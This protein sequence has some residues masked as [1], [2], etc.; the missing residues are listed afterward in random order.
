MM[1]FFTGLALVFLMFFCPSP[2]LRAGTF[3]VE[4]RAELNRLMVELRAQQFLTHATF[5]PKDT[6]VQ[7]LADRMMQ[8]GVRRAASEWIDTQFQLPASTHQQLAEDMVAADGFETTQASINVARY[9]YHAWWHNA[10]T[11]EDQLRQRVAWALMQICVVGESGSNFNNRAAGKLGKGR[12][13][14]LSNYYDMLLNNSFNNYRD[15]LGD[16]TF[17]PIMGV[18]LSH[19]RNQKQDASQNIFP[20]ENYAREILQLFSIGLYRL[21]TDGTFQRNPS[22]DLIPTYDN[23][24][25]ETF[26]RLFTG[27]TYNQSNSLRSGTVN[28]QEPMMMFDEF[29]DQD[30]KQV[31]LGQTLPGGVGGVADINAGLDNIM[32]HP[33]AG[34]FIVRRLIQRLVRSNPSKGYMRRVVRK[35]N[36]NGQGVKG[37]MKAV[38]KAILLDQEAWDGIRMVRRANPWRL[39]VTGRGT[40]RSRLSEPVVLYASFI[41]RYG[42]TDNPNGYFLM[43]KLNFNWA[44]APYASPSVFNFYLPDF[45]PAGDIKEYQASRRIPERTIYAPEFQILDGVFANRTPNRFRADVIN[46]ELVH[47][48]LN[49]STAVIRTTIS[50]DFSAEKALVSD[51]AALVAHLDAKLCCGTMS[52][53]TRQ[54][55]VETLNLTTNETN[56]FRVAMIGVLTSPAYSIAE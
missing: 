53:A 22:G 34:P 54:A 48:N 2:V 19:L 15:V 10:V 4:S 40:E 25:I 47:T 17:H 31:F 37:D 56:R 28:F 45:Q 1:R 24:E 11:A 23:T 18:W 46:E 50:Y 44:Q 43:N 29:H 51:S 35:F 55:L 5:G 21:N 41:R 36:N 12:W 39:E 49:N 14:G 16:V 32:N 26:A 52:N 8:I 20:D 13:L 7:A 42:S 27:L 38:L 30:P 3:E 6:D 33:S 9:R